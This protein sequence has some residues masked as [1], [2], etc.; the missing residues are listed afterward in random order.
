MMSRSIPYVRQGRV[1][2]KARTQAAMIE[3]VRQLLAEGLP[4]TVEAAAARAGISRATAYRYFANRRELVTAA[5]PEI[6]DASLLPSDATDDPVARVI[7]VAQA[8]M[9]LT[10]DWEPELRAALRLSLEPTGSDHDLEIRK[11]RRITWFED[12]LAP[13][14]ARLGDRRAHRLALALAAAVGIEPYIWLTDMAGLQPDDAS[15]MLCSTAEALVKAHLATST[16]PT[17]HP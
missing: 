2:Q 5:H 10:I 6:A 16:T 3:A 15:D 4:V 11:A 12:A 9:R 13:A 17:E 7:A 1:N 14:R 8:I